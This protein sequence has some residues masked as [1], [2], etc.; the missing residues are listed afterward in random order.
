[1]PW[2]VLHLFFLPVGLF[3]Q[4]DYTAYESL[5]A[6]YVSAEGKVD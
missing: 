1:M 4:P 6:R 2:L 3:A 5:L